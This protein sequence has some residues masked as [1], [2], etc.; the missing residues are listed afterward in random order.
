[1][2]G[3]QTGDMICKAKIKNAV[4][5]ITV[6]HIWYCPP[7]ARDNYK[8]TRYILQRLACLTGQDRR[9]AQRTNTTVAKVESN[10]RT[11]L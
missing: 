3:A 8:V 2:A 1:M 10:G 5:P 6:H 9:A 4:V 11:T 7:N